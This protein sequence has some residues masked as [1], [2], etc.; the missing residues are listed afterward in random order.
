MREFIDAKFDFVQ[1]MVDPAKVD[2][3]EDLDELL[4]VARR[5]C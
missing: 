5:L 3:E 2:V 4:L 1:L